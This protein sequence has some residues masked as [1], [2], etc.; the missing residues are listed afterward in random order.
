MAQKTIPNENKIVAN[1]KVSAEKISLAVQTNAEGGLTINVTPLSFESGGPVRFDIS[2]NTHQGDLN[3]DL[4][5]Q[6]LL[7]D[8][9]GREHRPV[10]WKGESGGHHLTGELVF[11][12]LDKSVKNVKLVVSGVYD[13][14]ERIFE[15]AL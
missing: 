4:M 11:P 8:D 10:E 6:S 15:W 3:F 7:T 9:K 5:K 1:E 13:V 12:S 2:F 14:K